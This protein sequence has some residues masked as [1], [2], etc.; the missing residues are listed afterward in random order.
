[1]NVVSHSMMAYIDVLGMAI[2]GRI[3]G[4]LERRLTVGRRGTELRREFLVLERIVFVQ[5]LE[6]ATVCCL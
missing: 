6:N 3:V 1:M 2:F 5:L 4:D